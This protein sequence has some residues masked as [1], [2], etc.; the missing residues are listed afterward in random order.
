MALTFPYSLATFADIIRLKEVTFLP[1]YGQE[2]SGK[3]SGM[4][5]AKDLR[6]ALW[7]ATCSTVTMRFDEANDVQALL[8]GLHGSVNTFYLY[9]PFRP[10]PKTG[11]VDDSTCTIKSVGSDGTSL[12][13][14]GLPVGT[15][16]SRG[17]MLSFY[18][19]SKPSIALHRA[20]ETVTAD[21]SGNTAE[22]QVGAVRAGAA[23]D[24]AVTLNKA[25]GEFRMISAFTQ[26]T[27][28][29]ITTSFSFN[30][31]QVL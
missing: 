22:F 3:A 4:I 5:I 14:K 6:P 31:I 18:Y 19:G 8:E 15:V 12:A 2:Y 27:D 10:Y 11:Q 26:N 9:N 30:C 17:D 7:M 1:S 16:I 20:L 28:S 23:A 29:T 25:Y 21:G 13:L 24:I